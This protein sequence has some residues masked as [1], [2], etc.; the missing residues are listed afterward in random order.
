MNFD[1][2]LSSAYEKCSAL[3]LP[4]NLPKNK[5][6][7]RYF[8]DKCNALLLPLLLYVR[9][10]LILPRATLYSYVAHFRFICQKCS[11]LLLSLPI[12]KI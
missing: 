8:C 9:R 2:S 6:R 1:K 4:L 7:S 10:Y 3:P 12:P 11:A 5:A